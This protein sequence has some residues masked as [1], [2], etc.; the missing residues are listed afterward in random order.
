[1]EML[2]S[3]F[4][5]FLFSTLGGS[6]T[7]LVVLAAIGLF[8]RRISVRL[9]HVLWLIVLVRLLLPAFPSSPV[10]LFQLTNINLGQ[11]LSFA[12]YFTSNVETEGASEAIPLAPLIGGRI[13]E[14]EESPPFIESLSAGTLQMEEKA[15]RGIIFTMFSWLWIAGVATM[16]AVILRHWWRL[17]TIFRQMRLIE[18]ARLVDILEECRVKLGIKG[19]IGLYTG[20]AATSGPFIYGVFRPKVYLPEVLCQSLNGE[21]LS[22]VLMH[23]LAHR[24]RY[25]VLWN[26][27]GSVALAIHWMNPLVWLAIKKMKADR[28]LACDACVLNAL[29]SREVLPYGQTI[30]EV[31]RAFASRREQGQVIGFSGAGARKQLERRLIMIKD[32][33]K[34]SYKLT[35]ASVLC[36]I[37]ICA[38]TLTNAAAPAP[39]R[40]AEQTLKSKPGENTVLFEASTGS[41]TYNNVEKA[42]AVADFSFKIPAAIP[43]TY[44][45]ESAS[46]SMGLNKDG[47][48]G[49]NQVIIVFRATGDQK[50]DLNLTAESR[51]TDIEQAYAAMEEK[52]K[53]NAKESD[54]ELQL[55]KQMENVNG[56]DILKVEVS[57]GKANY[58]RYLW[59][60]EGIQYV[61]GPF[62]IEENNEAS[63]LIASM[64]KPELPLSDRLVNKSLLH[65]KIYDTDDISRGRDA[66]G[67][68]PKFPLH[69]LERYFATDASY[70][71]MVNFGYANNEADRDQRVL[72]IGY[73]PLDVDAGNGEAEPGAEE[74]QRFSFK[75]IKNSGIIRELK[76]SGVA[77]FQRIDRQRFTAPVSMVTLEG[78][79]VYR[80]EPYKIDGELSSA[81]EPDFTSYFWQEDEALF[82]VQFVGNGGSVMDEIVA[83]LILQNPVDLN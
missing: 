31:L 83:A 3:A 80:T 48:E 45:F 15:M 38:S 25:D 1:M 50:Y 77:S 41:R 76:N 75:Q 14:A 30:L 29:G 71:T 66:L 12:P 63:A 40:Q 27:L 62:G 42:V 21:Q 54:V 60:D 8:R 72:S 24:K 44:R 16:L 2:D 18:E 57:R 58:V 47:E 6:I 73:A 17:K 36:V 55:S 4:K 78:Q 67:F 37:A 46:L 52:E 53:F 69:V 28:E 13:K 64:D 10:N 34:G 23:E 51:G 43:D 7:I 5:W 65:A 79:E 19:R 11:M 39:D 35:A 20:G 49:L 22:H 68:T 74:L 82:Q 56:M 32:F 9:R 61:M 70:T 59:Q 26:W 33:K 81:D